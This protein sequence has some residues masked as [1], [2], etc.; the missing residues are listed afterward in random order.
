MLANGHPAEAVIRMSDEEVP[1]IL[2]PGPSVDTD[3]ARHLRLMLR[4]CDL[5]S[6]AGNLTARRLPAW[7]LYD[8]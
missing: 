6:P 1:V 7:R 2:D 3:G 4:R 8:A 5:L